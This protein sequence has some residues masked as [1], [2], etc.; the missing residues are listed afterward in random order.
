MQFRAKVFQLKILKT[1]ICK[2][3]FKQFIKRGYGPYRYPFIIKKTA[4]FNKVII[5]DKIIRQQFLK[6]YKNFLAKKNL[7]EMRF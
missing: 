1:T 2:T 4:G 5:G 3:I 7:T 6:N